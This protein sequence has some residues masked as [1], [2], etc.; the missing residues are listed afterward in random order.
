MTN[1]DRVI[2]KMT[3]E[4]LAKIL[5]AVG[6]PCVMCAYHNKKISCSHCLEGI[7]EWLNQEEK[8]EAD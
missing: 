3:P 6:A 1:Y 5:D 8:D 2:S 4:L 7:K